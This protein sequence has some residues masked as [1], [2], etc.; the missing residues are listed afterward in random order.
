MIV[1]VGVLS[2]LPMMGVASTKA[3][4][5]NVTAPTT[6]QLCSGDVDWQVLGFSAGQLETPAPGELPLARLARGESA[7]LRV[8]GRGVGDGGLC[9][10][11]IAQV[12]WRADDPAVVE[13]AADGARATVIGRRL[14]Q[15]P[16][17][18]EVTRRDGRTSAAELFATNAA[19]QRQPLFG[20]RVVR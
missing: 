1:R 17:I 2:L 7:A 10:D 4:E 6:E 11:R 20:I 3:C 9:D 18:V 15:T 14:G 5:T 16:L 19:G 13:V 12:S 8:T